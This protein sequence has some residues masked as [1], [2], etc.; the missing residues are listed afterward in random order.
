[1]DTVLIELKHE[2]A[3][4][5]LQDLEAMNIIRVVRPAQPITEGLAARFAGSIPADEADRLD[6]YIKQSR[7]EW[8]RPI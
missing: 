2:K 5:L 3:H 7:D 1:M 8:E 6:E 4:A